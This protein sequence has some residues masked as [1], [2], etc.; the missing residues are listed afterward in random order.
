MVIPKAAECPRVEGSPC[1]RGLVGFQT[2][3]SFSV[4]IEGGEGASQPSPAQP[5]G[6]QLH[7][8]ALSTAQGEAMISRDQPHSAS[9]AQ[10]GQT[11]SGQVVSA[12]WLP[13][14]VGLMAKGDVAADSVCTWACLLPG[15]P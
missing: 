6:D 8:A 10:P 7:V 5:G 2:C 14:H 12:S 4:S 11:P 1:P 3:C 13:G 15:A 9:A